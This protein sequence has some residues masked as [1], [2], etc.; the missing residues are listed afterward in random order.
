MKAKGIITGIFIADIALL[1]VSAVLYSRQDRVVPAISFSA[2]DIVYE[3]G[4]DESLLMEGVSA[5]DDRD[6]DVS[7]SLLIEKI[8][9]TSQGD[10]IVT[11]A[12]M[13]SSNNVAKAS[14]VFQTRKMRNT[15]EQ[16][17]GE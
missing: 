5:S 12:A 15:G 7:E 8:S 1:A 3:E 14:R 11:Y 10:V 9:T 16:T 6:G 2:N 4:M 17:G 13:D